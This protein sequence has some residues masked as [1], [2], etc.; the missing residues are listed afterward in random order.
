[1]IIFQMDVNSSFLNGVL[2]EEWYLE[3]P[4]EYMKIGEEKKVLKLKKV[5][6]VLKQTLRAWNI[7]IDTYFKKN[8]F[9]QCPYKHA[10][11]GRK[12]S[13]ICYL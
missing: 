10:L 9:T 6:Y 3:L 13:V 5:V 7:F 1:M 8:E 12:K 11:Y 2:E 4:L